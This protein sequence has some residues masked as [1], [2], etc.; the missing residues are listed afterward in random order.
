MVGLFLPFN[1]FN[2]LFIRRPSSGSQSH[3]MKEGIFFEKGGH[4]SCPVQRECRSL[5]VLYKQQNSTLSKRLIDSKEPFRAVYSIY[6]HEYLG[7][8]LSAHVV[9]EL[10]NGRLSLYHQGLYPKN[11]SQFAHKLDERDK[12]L[13]SLLFDLTENEIIRRF[14]KKAKNTAEFYLKYFSPEIKKLCL[15]FVNRKVAEAMPLLAGRELGV[16]GN[17]GYPIYRPV[18]VLEDK[19]SVLF[20]FKR[21]EEETRY[22]PTVKL[23]G[24]KLDFQ[25]QEAEIV[26]NQPAWMLLHNELFTFNKD[27]DGRKLKPFL[28]KWYIS[29]SKATEKT[30]FEKFV[31]GLVEKYDV[32]ARGFDI[33]TEKHAPHFTLTVNNSGGVITSALH[34]TYDRFVLSLDPDNRVKAVMENHEDEYTFFRVVRRQDAEREILDF[35]ES[36]NPGDG[37]WKWEY[38]EEQQG[39]A[40][41]SENVARIEEMGIEVRQKN[42]DN[43]FNFNRPEINLET[44]EVGDW[45]DIKAV[46][47]IGKFHIPFLKFRGH[48]LKGKRDYILP[49]GTIAILPD[50]WFSEYRHLMEVAES[51]EDDTI[52]IRKYQAGLLKFEESGPGMNGF[53]KKLRELMESEEIGE[54][55]ELPKGVKAELRTYQKQGY[56]WLHFLK[57][58]SFGG[59]LADDMGLGKTLQ[60]LTLMLREKEQGNETPSLIVMPTSLIYNW[61]SEAKKFTPDLKVHVHTGV[62]R[63]KDPAKFSKYDLILTTYGLVRQDLKQLK[64]FPF[65]YIILDESQMIKNP[66]SKTAKAV[67]ELI[68]NHRLSLSGTPLENSLMDLWSQ[69]SFL[70]PGLLGSEAFFKNFY[71]T[72]IEKSNDEKRKEQLKKLLHPFILR[73]TKEQVAEELPPKVENIHYCEMDES[74]EKFYEETK[75]SYRNY[76]LNFSSP[77][78]FNKNK[79]NILAGLQKLR[80]IAIHPKLINPETLPGEPSET[81]ESMDAIGSAK[82]KEFRRLL[83]EVLQKGAKVLVFSQFVKLLKIIKTDLEKDKTSFAY[84]DGGTKDR[85]EQ[86]RKFQEDDSIQVF[87]ISL[88][89]GGVG[90]NLTAAEYVFILDPWWNPA[91]ENQAI[92]RSHRIGQKK[93]V[94]FYKFI[95][96]DTIEEKILKL[97]ARKAKL[98]R[99]IVTVEEE[100][101]KKLGKEDLESLLL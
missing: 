77:T 19:A 8:L 52:S 11:F 34:V 84:L 32:Y 76:L 24:E 88:K 15:E 23:G 49:D 57:G 29:I 35:M 6:R 51:K 58:F 101:Y 17:D 1:P 72:P 43:R 39:L 97:Q 48:I 71:C 18:T 56:D 53:G 98:S 38:M 2:P 67:K 10:P 50:T 40:W 46:V 81:A 16:M 96:K 70:N 44:T 3:R 99:D 27:V 60:T 26:C 59:I 54:D 92:D 95:T 14:S 55:Q 45:F 78:E 79:F 47:V 91:V 82:Y 22:Y 20:H 69:M 5:V 4:L 33:L 73:R 75:N 94:F 42:K 85:Q 41:L 63:S 90:L 31:P 64:P 9:E 74:Q 12:K 37:L 7:C 21:R 68:A 80:Q 65:H 83:E 86:V 100:V 61:L 87:L 25:Y 13:V 62:N 89:A 28:K 93:T 30:Y 66:A 36:L